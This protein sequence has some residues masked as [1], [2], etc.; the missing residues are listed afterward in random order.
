ML[1]RFLATVPVEAVLETPAASNLPQV[2]AS[3]AAAAAAVASVGVTP[4]AEAPSSAPVAPRNARCVGA[5]IAAAP[6]QHAR[7]LRAIVLRGHE[8]ARA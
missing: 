3:I 2:V 4:Q 6:A 1:R 8:L 7:A 5:L